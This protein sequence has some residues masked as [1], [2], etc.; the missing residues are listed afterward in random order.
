VISVSDGAASTALPPFT[1]EVTEAP[2]RAPALSGAP[3]TTAVVGELYTFT[4]T[5]SDADGDRLAFSI[6]GKPG[7]ASFDATTGRLS[8]TPASTQVGTYSGIVISASD[9]EATTSLPSFAI[10]VDP[11]ALRAV[12]LSWQAPTQNEDG[13]PLTDLV[14]YEVH[15]GQAA[16]QYSQT[17]SLPSA[18]LTSVTVEDLTPATW[19]FAVKAVNSSGVQSSFSSEA[20]KTIN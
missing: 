4:P 6:S 12:T 7:W 13:T 11:P 1:I 10:R 15:Y 16:G 3:R 20:W 14:G 19:Y 2:N 18:A 17:L 9:G 5:A 8:G